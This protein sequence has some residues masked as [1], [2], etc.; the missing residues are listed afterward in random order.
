MTEITVSLA[1]PAPPPSRRLPSPPPGGGCGRAAPPRR[2]S[3]LKGIL[4][5]SAKTSCPAPFSFAFAII[6]FEMSMPT[7]SYSGP[8]QGQCKPPGADPDVEDGPL[9][10]N[11][12]PHRLYEAGH[13]GLGKR[14]GRV[15]DVGDP[16]EVLDLQQGAG[17]GS[18]RIKHP[19][20]APGAAT[21]D[22]FKDFKA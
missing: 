6:P 15:V 19:E 17:R 22:R 1:T 14:P 13:L 12:P 2:S 7:T 9:A 10:V 8:L 11:A 20:Q 3:S 5:M 4:W 16:P 18:C 21:E